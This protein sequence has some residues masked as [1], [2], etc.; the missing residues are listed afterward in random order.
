MGDMEQEHPILNHAYIDARKVVVQEV[1][2]MPAGENPLQSEALVIGL[3]L[4]GNATFEYNMEP[5]VFVPQE[6]GV[7]L[8]NSL[9][10]YSA[11]SDDYQALLVI[12]S[13]DFFNDLIR[14]TAFMDYKKYYYHP[15]CVLNGDQYEKIR[16]I[17]RVLQIISDSEHP[18]RIETLENLLDI[19][20]YTLTRYRGEEGVKSES[21]KRSEQLFNRFYDLLT[22][23][24]AEHHEI[25]WY[26]AQL[27]LTPK[28]FSSVIRHTTDKSAAEWISIVLIMQAKKLLRTRRNWT[29]QQVAYELGFAENAT[30]CRF[31]KDQTG[32]TPTRFRMG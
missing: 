25:G 12:V 13:K 9:M 20:F 15:S 23:Y 17:L 2:S 3:C 30:F 8:P 22:T 14:R 1:Q 19:L 28:Y 5:K 18:K 6:V 16:S 10:A 21:E 4:S 26:A 29:V 11:T 7:T 31:F 24:Y 27:S 32:Q